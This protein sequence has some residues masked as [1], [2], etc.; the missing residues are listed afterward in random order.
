[1]S[2]YV[3]LIPLAL[4]L[5]FCM[6]MALGLFNRNDA[7]Q[8]SR[9]LGEK[10]GTFDLA[11][12]GQPMTHFSPK[13]WQGRIIV[14]NVFASWCEPCNIEH[15]VIM[16][17]AKSGKA[18]VLGIAWKDKEENIRRWINAHGNP[19]QQIGLDPDG[20]TTVSLGLS[21]V[22]ETLV[23]DQNGIIIYNKKAP[24]SEEDVDKVLLP[25]LSKLQ[26]EY[27]PNP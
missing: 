23:I 15:P 7:L 10:P 5:L 11:V 1:M 16:K 3:R 6:L 17:L 26:A 24:L 9:M 18:V 12:I 14:L 20:H 13:Q 2:P 21:G 27:A 19:Y 22:P 4:L 25:L 8:E